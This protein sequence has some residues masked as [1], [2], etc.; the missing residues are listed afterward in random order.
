MAEIQKIGH[1]FFASDRVMT[2]CTPSGTTEGLFVFAT[3]LPYRNEDIDWDLAMLENDLYPSDL[4]ASCSVVAL[5]GDKIVCDIP[6]NYALF[7]TDDEAGEVGEREDE[8]IVIH[9]SKR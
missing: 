1:W 9:W 2:I 8:E 5:N 3:P 4:L 7:I 6:D